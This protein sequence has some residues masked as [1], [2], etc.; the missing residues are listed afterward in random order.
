MNYESRSL[1]DLRALARKAKITGRSY[2]NKADLVSALRTQ[3]G[4]RRSKLL[5]E[6]D[7][8]EFSRLMWSEGRVPKYMYANLRA[9][10]QVLED[11]DIFFW[12][13]EGTALG[14]IREGRIIPGDS[15]VDVGVWS[16][17]RKRFLAAAVPKLKAAGFRVGRVYPFSVFRDAHYIDVDFT[18]PGKR[19]MAIEWPRPCDEFLDTLEPF[20]TAKLKGLTYVVPSLRYI[21]KLY[22]KG[23]RVP[24]DVKP[25]DVQ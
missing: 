13:G 19:C 8:K 14:A 5:S 1:K 20:S 10:K 12:L 9:F 16:A 3:K 6:K 21:K 7:R 23:W 22:G 2:M 4:R 18:G 15:D 24:Q 11:L 17:D 25:I